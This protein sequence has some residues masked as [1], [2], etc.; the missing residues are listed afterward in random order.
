YA[1]WAG[2]EVLGLGRLIVGYAVP[3]GPIPELPEVF[4]SELRPEP[5]MDL[6]DRDPVL[7]ADLTDAL[8]QIDP[9]DFRGEHDIW[10]ELLMACKFVG[11]SLADFVEWSTS[12]PDYADHG[13]IIERKWRSIEPRHGGAFWREVNTRGI[14]VRHGHQ[15]THARHPFT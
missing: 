15:H 13:A 10:F 3:Q 7:V 9:C 14:K 11:I 6:G 4:W 5:S 2:G 12:D 1:K 8:R